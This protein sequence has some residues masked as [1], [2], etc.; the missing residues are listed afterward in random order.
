MRHVCLTVSLQHHFCPVAAFFRAHAAGDVC[1]MT[2]CH[3]DWALAEHWGGWMERTQ[4]Q[5][6]GAEFCDFKWRAESPSRYASKA[7]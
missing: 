4:T 6:E 1:L 2:W 3:Q 7:R 5:A